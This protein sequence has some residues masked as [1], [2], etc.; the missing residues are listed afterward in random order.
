MHDQTYKLLEELLDQ[1]HNSSRTE[2]SALFNDFIKTNPAFLD[3]A[4]SMLHGADDIKDFLEE[5]LISL[6]RELLMHGLGRSDIPQRI[7]AYEILDTLGEGGM[8]RVYLA[9][10]RA[11]VPRKVALK[12]LKQEDPSLVLRLELEAQALACLDHPNVARILDWGE[13]D[14]HSPFFTM[15][16]FP[17]EHIT[18]FCRRESLTIRQRVL[19][20]LQVCEGIGHIHRKGILHRD[21]KPSNILVKRHDHKITAK[22]IDFGIAREMS[23]PLGEATL[24]GRAGAILGTL[25]YMSP[26]QTKGATTDLDIRSDIYSAAAVLY[27]LLTGVPP[28]DQKKL[29][30]YSIDKVIRMIREEDVVP[31]SNR[32]LKESADSKEKPA[33][34]AKALRGEVDWILSKALSK[35]PERRYDTVSELAADLERYRKGEPVLAGPV[36]GFYQTQ[37]FIGRHRLAVLTSVLLLFML[38]TATT[39]STWSML[40]T[41][42]ARDQAILEA[43]KTQALHEFFT[44][45]L[46]SPNPYEKDKDI[47]L[48]DALDEVAR[49]ADR[50]YQ[51]YPAIRLD[52]HRTLGNTYK[53]LGQAARAERHLRTAWELSR[54]LHGLDHPRTLILRYALAESL[55]LD[56]RPDLS[57]RVLTELNRHLDSLP[58]GHRLHFQTGK[59]A[60]HLLREEGRMGEARLAYQTL[61]DSVSRRDVEYLDALRGLGITE[62]RVGN[63][64]RALDCYRRVLSLQVERDIPEAH[65]ERLHT[66]NNLANIN[67][68]LGNLERA[69]ELYRDILITRIAT[70]GEEHPSTIISLHNLGN[71]LMGAGRF[72]ESRS[73]LERAVFLFEKVRG[74]YHHHTMTARNNLGRLMLN[75]EHYADAEWHYREWYPR[76]VEH[77]GSQTN[78]SLMLGHNLGL[79]LLEQEKFQE[80]EKVLEDILFKRETQFGGSHA[81]TILTRFVLGRAYLGQNAV[82]K[83][84]AHFRRARQDVDEVHRPERAALYQSYLGFSLLQSGQKGEGERH[85]RE[86]YA[87]LPEGSSPERERIDILFRQAQVPLPGKEVK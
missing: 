71:H 39:I 40:Q 56:R 10:Q 37:K 27:E 76:T 14:R 16:Y 79:S 30:T 13:T 4:R 42:K 87:L 54:S 43:Q 77:L 73:T 45:I 78:I 34:L 60:A 65:H 24:A 51:D 18:R 12:V 1:A 59:L 9:Y 80:A 85:L 23:K 83:A 62:G 36:S 84:A 72:G 74:P 25:S 35:D 49:Q 31:P 66:L 44:Q 58:T 29:N 41:R 11:P 2:K 5:P 50:S 70:L 15:E 28:L 81:D 7:G 82:D 38:I 75:M 22:I 52:I 17:G 46:A 86:G 61:I 3:E 68:E 55:F 57:R 6:V 20:F 48:V 26:E 47:K 19:L 53:G 69:E 32:V 21:L 33:R 63:Y 8:G 64:T 67:S